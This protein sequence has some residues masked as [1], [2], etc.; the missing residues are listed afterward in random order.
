MDWL[1]EISSN[2]YILYSV[3]FLGSFWDAWIVSN[4][5]IHGEVFFL[6][7]GYAGGQGYINIYLAFL[8]SILWALAGD[9]ISYYLWKKHGIKFFSEDAR[10]LNIKN[11]KKWEDLFKRYGSKTILISRLL[12]PISWITPCLAGIFW[13]KYAKFSFFNFIGVCIWVGQFIFYGY[14]VSLGQEYFSTTIIIN[15]LLIILTVLSWI[16]LYRNILLHVHN[17]KNQLFVIFKII[18]IYLTIFF[19]IL[20][21]YFFYLYPSSAKFYSGDAYIP[22]IKNYLEET[23]RF[24]YSDKVVK[25]Y[26][27]PINIV[28]ITDRDILQVF[29]NINW[30]KNQSFS[31]DNITFPS[32]IES[33][34][35]GTPPISDFYH[36]E[37]T[38]NYQFQN[39]WGKSIVR[40]HIRL[41]HIWKTENGKNIYLSSISEDDALW[42]MI[43]NGLLIL[44]HDI[45]HNIDISRDAFVQTIGKTYDN[46]KVENFPYPVHEWGS[47][48]TDWIVKILEF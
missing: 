15:S 9:H 37:Q 12:G 29:N 33:L 1:S 36:Q 22:D 26:Y 27:N 23:D 32:Y 17:K 45:E 8:V 6:A 41:W 43:S 3:L 34:R 25:L 7:A 31:S 5:F 39:A 38:Q 47:F 18:W 16:Y 13:V 40:D 28:L 46:L 24:I 19:A 21:I 30:K 42:L 20:A 2:I 11:L 10:F 48:E 35:L 4:F 44:W 14:C